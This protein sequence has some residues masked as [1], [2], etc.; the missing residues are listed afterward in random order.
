M[1][2]VFDRKLLPQ[3]RDSSLIPDYEVD[4][5]PITLTTGTARTISFSDPAN[6]RQAIPAGYLPGML[7][8]K[9]GGVFYEGQATPDTTNTDREANAE[10]S[11]PVQGRPYWVF[12]GDTGTIIKGKVYL[13]S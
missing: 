7:V 3:A 2:S 1:A 6:F 12:L 13:G 9:A 10:Y 4:L 11:V 8:L 5:V